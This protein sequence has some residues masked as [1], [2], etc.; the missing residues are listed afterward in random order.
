M[1][2]PPGSRRT[3]GAKRAFIRWLKAGH[4]CLD[5]GGLFPPQAIDF[6]HC[7]GVKT[8]E[9]SQGGSHGHHG[10]WPRL[11]GATWD[12]VI[13]EL[14]KCDVVC[15]GCHKRRETAALVFGARKETNVRPH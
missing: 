10:E 5:C 13:E 6:D 9:L 14:A 2:P 7:R 4:P 3:K 8:M 12:Q 11:P 1:T 15:K